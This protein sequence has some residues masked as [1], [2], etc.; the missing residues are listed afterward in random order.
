[1]GKN[2]RKFGFIIC[3]NEEQYFRECCLYINQLQVPSGFTVDIVPV[4]EAKSMTSGYNNGMYASDAQYKIYMHQD[5]FIINPNF[6]FDILTVFKLNWKIG[7]IGMIGCPVLPPTGVMWHGERVGNLY[8]LDKNNVNFNGYEYQREDGITEVEAIDGLLMVTKEDIPWREDLFDGWDFYDVS[9]S[10]EF[11]RKG[12]KIVVP[13]Q[14]H[15][16]CAHDDGKMNLWSYDRYRK[17][18]L[19]EYMQ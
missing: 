18:F 9:Q 12:L 2:K 11:R 10:F 14:K 7:M 19:K 16:W 3:T 17:I 5:V 8:Q 13:E 15:P 4:M 1:M 6:L